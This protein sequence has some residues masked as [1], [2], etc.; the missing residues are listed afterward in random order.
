MNAVGVCGS[1]E[2]VCTARGA[3]S[4]AGGEAA[5]H[6][7]KGSVAHVQAVEAAEA[8]AEGGHHGVRWVDLVV[9]ALTGSGCVNFRVGNKAVGV[10]VNLE[11][12]L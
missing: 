9:L 6:G 3:K 8:G 1:R 12:F 10:Q 5:A 4:G 2:R 11:R 7:A